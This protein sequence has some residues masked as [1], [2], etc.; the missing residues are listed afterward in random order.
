MSLFNFTTIKAKI[1]QVAKMALI[2]HCKI[3]EDTFANEVTNYLT[4]YCPLPFTANA[5]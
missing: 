4:R 5:C 3:C 1:E 2:L